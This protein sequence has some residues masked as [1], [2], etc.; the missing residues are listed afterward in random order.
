VLSAATLAVLTNPTGPAY[1]VMTD[2][3]NKLLDLAF[4]ADPLWNPKKNPAVRHMYI[5]ESGPG[6]GSSAAAAAPLVQDKQPLL[7]FWTQ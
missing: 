1:N 2:N 4:S 3:V 7:P 6:L 5:G